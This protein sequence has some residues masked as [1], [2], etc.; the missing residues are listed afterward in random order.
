MLSEISGCSAWQIPRPACSPELPPR[1]VLCPAGPTDESQVWTAQDEPAAYKGYR[2]AT[3]HGRHYRQGSSYTKTHKEDT[4]YKTS[5]KRDTAYGGKHQEDAPPY[6]RD[7]HR[8]T[9]Y[10]KE[11]THHKK[12]YKGDASYGE[13]EAPY[14][15]DYK[16]STDYNED[17]KGYG[18]EH[19]KK[20]PSC[21]PIKGGLCTEDCQ[22]LCGTG[23]GGPWVD[24]TLSRHNES[25]GTAN[26]SGRVWAS[27]FRMW[28]I[29]QAANF[30]LRQW[31]AWGDVAPGVLCL[32]M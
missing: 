7:Y 18:E 11:E 32:A 6:E 15:A 25:C 3:R 30:A 17:H 5:Y 27:W 9:S 21:G 29:T 31:F 14:D 1:G 24:S 13:G 26:L 22:S 19:Y 12:Y 4:P 16:P 28:V 2:G 8:D 10:D 20:P 23:Q